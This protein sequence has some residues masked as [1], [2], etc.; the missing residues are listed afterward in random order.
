MVNMAI[1]NPTERGWV[2][3]IRQ[4]EDV[5]QH[6][7]KEALKLIATD[8]EGCLTAT[9]AMVEVGRR[10]WMTELKDWVV[11]SGLFAVEGERRGTRYQLQLE[12]C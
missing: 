4:E 3:L 11:D 10:K 6:Y 12:V 1:V 9:A 5:V 2:A 7:Q 8:N